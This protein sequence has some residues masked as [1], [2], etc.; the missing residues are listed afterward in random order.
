[1]EQQYIEEQPNPPEMFL[2]DDRKVDNPKET[3]C[4]HEEN[5]MRTNTQ[6]VSQSQ[7]EVRDYRALKYPRM[8]KVKSRIFRSFY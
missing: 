4:G 8:L 1:M 2:G 7:D 6:T 3:R 5:S